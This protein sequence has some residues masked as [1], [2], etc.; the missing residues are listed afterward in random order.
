MGKPIN[1]SLNEVQKCIDCCHH[2]QHQLHKINDA[3]VV[4]KGQYMPVGIVLGIMPWN[5][6]LWQ[7]IRCIVPAICAGNTVLINLLLTQLKQQKNSLN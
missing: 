1:E 2:F 4:P 6:P 7:L 5:F 3:M